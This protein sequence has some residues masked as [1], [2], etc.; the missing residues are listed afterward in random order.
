MRVSGWVTELGQAPEGGRIVV[1]GTRSPSQ[2]A[3]VL[4]FPEE[5]P[6]FLHPL[7]GE[8]FPELPSAPAGPS[9]QLLHGRAYQ[10]SFFSLW[11]GDSAREMRL[12]K[13]SYNSTVH[14]NF[15]KP[16]RQREP[17][18]LHVWMEKLRQRQVKNV[19]GPRITKVSAW[20]GEMAQQLR[21]LTVLPEVL[22]S[23]SSNHMVAHDH[24]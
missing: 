10:A 22:S 17:H 3:W 24:L 8:F 9:T 1:V 23:I 5:S 20:A 4:A 6:S 11:Y 2:L 13:M 12:Q 7:V 16:D 19:T 15:H 18:Q 14:V 21:T